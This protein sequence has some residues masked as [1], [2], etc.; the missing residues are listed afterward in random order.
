VVAYGK[1]SLTDGAIGEPGAIA[2]GRGDP[3]FWRSLGVGLLIAGIVAYPVNRWLIARG[4][5]H[6]VVHA[7]HA[8]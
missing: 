1:C 8:G 7:H 3:L 2:A 5:G 4:Q 6:A